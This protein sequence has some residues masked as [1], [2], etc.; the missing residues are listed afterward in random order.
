MASISTPGTP[1]QEMI[2]PPEDHPDLDRLVTEDNKAV[3]NIRTEKQMRLLVEPLYSTWP[4]P[5]EGRSFLALANV[6][7][8]YAVNEPPLVPDV[9]VSLDVPAPADL[10]KKENRSYFV[11]IVGKVPDAVVEIVSDKEGREDTDKLKAYARLRIPYYVIYDPRNRLGA[12][13]LRIY[14]LDHR[15]YKLEPTNLLADVGLAV[16]LWHGPF[17]GA[18]GEWLRWCDPQGKVL[19]TGS[20]LAEEQRREKEQAQHRAERLAEQ[21]RRLGVEPEGGSV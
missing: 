9:M 4:G 13:K 1:Q 7:L 11:W 17:E 8:F 16:T 14:G 15:S 2:L 10:T 19:L 20:E 12:G 18:E 5:G 6:G 3:D 21:L